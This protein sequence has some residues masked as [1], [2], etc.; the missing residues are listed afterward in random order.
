MGGFI[1]SKVET[2]DFE[3]RKVE[4]KI[5]PIEYADFIAAEKLQVDEAELRSNAELQRQIF[6][7]MG[8]VVAKYVELIAPPLDSAGDPV[9]VKEICAH[10]YFMKL[11]ESLYVAVVNTGK[12]PA[13]LVSGGS[14][15]SG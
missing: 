3:G 1:R 12:I 9:T 2:F 5:K 14:L 13:P 8:A 11:F 10:P 4:A 7:G 15:P 6:E